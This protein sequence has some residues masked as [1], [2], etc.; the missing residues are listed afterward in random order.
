[1]VSAGAR[2]EASFWWCPGADDE[3]NPT[4]QAAGITNNITSNRCDEAQNDDVECPKNITNLEAREKMRQRFRGEQV[5][6]HGSR[7]AAAVRRDASH[8]HD[9]IYDEQRSHGRR[10]S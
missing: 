6:H 10:L 8:A 2:G 5:Q 9:S 7:R 1:M 4:M 3:R